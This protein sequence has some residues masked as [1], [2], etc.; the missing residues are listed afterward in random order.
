MGL[1]EIQ[2]KYSKNEGAT[3]T[4]NAHIALLQGLIDKYNVA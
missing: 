2:K 3:R 4:A 1:L